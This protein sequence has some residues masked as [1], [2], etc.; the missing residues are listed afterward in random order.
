MLY[1]LPKAGFTC[2][3]HVANPWYALSIVGADV[4]PTVG[5]RGLRRC[6]QRAVSSGGQTRREKENATHWNG[7]R[8]PFRVVVHP[9]HTPTVFEMHLHRCATATSCGGRPLCGDSTAFRVRLTV[10]DGSSHSVVAGVQVA[11]T[12]ATH[13]AL[14]C[15]VRGAAAAAAAGRRPRY[16]RQRTHDHDH[17]AVRLRAAARSCTAAQPASL[18]PHTIP[19]FNKCTKSRTTFF[20]HACIFLS[21]ASCGRAFM[22]PRAAA[23]VGRS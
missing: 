3:G 9:V 20:Q 7:P 17:D 6:G 4:S 23:I 10:G 12:N 5:G 21:H 22:Q 8:A 14:H 2:I 1:T 19:Y 16:H 13:G 11:A 18:S 15:G